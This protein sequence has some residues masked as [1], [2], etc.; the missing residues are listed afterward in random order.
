[1]TWSTSLSV[2]A[3][4]IRRVGVAATV[5]HAVDQQG[6]V[7]A[8]GQTKARGGVVKK[9]PLCSAVSQEGSADKVSPVPLDLDD[10]RPA[11]AVS[12]TAPAVART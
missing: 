9:S 4:F 8:G 3:P 10:A 1:M 2:M 7:K 6:E 5:V 11:R 12:R